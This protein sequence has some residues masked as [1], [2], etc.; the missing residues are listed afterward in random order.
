MK[1]IGILSDT[2]SHWD[3]KYSLYFA[4]CDEI[5]HAGDIGDADL[6]DRLEGIGPK[7]RAVSG[8]IDHGE[9]RRRCP[10]L[11]IFDCEGVK[12]LLTHIGGYPG[13]WAPGMKRLL[14]EEGVKLMVDGHSHLTKVMYD[15]ELDLLHINPGAAGRQ[16]WQKQ[17]TLIRLTIDGADM[18]DCEVIELA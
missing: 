14:R 1:R 17:R 12:V 3:D 11:L 7:L 8:N 15:P 13:R 9:V 6:L 10:E 5:W 4:D 2:H 18:R 16:G